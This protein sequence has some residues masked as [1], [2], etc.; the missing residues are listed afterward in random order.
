LI[1]VFA[2]STKGGGLNKTL[3]G[4]LG[5]EEDRRQ[6]DGGILMDFVETADRLPH[7]SV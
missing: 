6:T 5:E 3:E 4:E 7:L 1:F 2:G